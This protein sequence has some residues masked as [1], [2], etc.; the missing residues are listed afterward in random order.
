MSAPEARVILRLKL[1]EADLDRADALAAKA[2]SGHLAPQEDREL[3][4][5]L[6]I[7]SALEFLKAKARRSLRKGTTMIG[8]TAIGRATIVVAPRMP[9]TVGRAGG[10]AIRVG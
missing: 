2:R 8:F 6:T 7:G 9:R 1:A 3:E 5:Y 4:N 10:R